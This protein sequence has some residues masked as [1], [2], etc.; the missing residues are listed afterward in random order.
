MNL[1]LTPNKSAASPDTAANAPRRRRLTRLPRR[2][3]MAV[4]LVIVTV[5]LVVA[6]GSM[7]WTPYDPDASGVG[8]PYQPPSAE[9]WFGTDRVGAD[10]FSRT[11]AAAATDV[12]I[13]LAAVLIALVVGTVV[14]AVSGFVGG[15][16]DTV[17]MRFMEILQ[18]FPALL[19][20]MLMVAA[21]GPG[22]LNVIV[23]V[24]I[25][26]IPNY[27]R[28]VRA[29]ILSKK[30][31]Q[32]AEAARMVGNSRSRVLFRHLL[33]NSMTPVI[34]FSSVNASW[35]AVIVASLGFIGL[36]IE[37]GSA[38][39]GSM[40]SRGQDS[41]LSGEWWISTFPGIAILVLSAAFYL[42]GDGLTES[43]EQ[44]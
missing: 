43:G 41:I 31:W 20:A 42:I 37:P 22:T 25:V 38:E 24:S 33:P 21:V 32:F 40:I 14:G 6:V 29:E 19:L 16:V 27:V 34:G 7:F 11:M 39:W 12:G 4:G 26:G 17:V 28:L 15:A 9:H 44:R 8:L 13:T 1:T 30:H 18:A 10:V 23:V 5:L 35:V 3:S 2:G 36:G